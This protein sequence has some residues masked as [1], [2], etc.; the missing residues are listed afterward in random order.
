MSFQASLYRAPLVN[1]WWNYIF[2]GSKAV[3][4]VGEATGGCWSKPVKID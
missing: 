4:T 3:F 2:G 1:I